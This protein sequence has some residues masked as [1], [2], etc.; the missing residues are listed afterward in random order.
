[1]CGKEED[2]IIY[3]MGSKTAIM[4]WRLQVETPHNPFRYC[5]EYYDD[6][7]DLIYLR[8]RYYDNQ[9]GRFITEDPIKDSLNWYSYCGNNP[10]MFIDPW[11]LKDVPLRQFVEERGGTVVW[12]SSN[13]S[14]TVNFGSA[15]KKTYY[16]GKQ[17]TKSSDSYSSENPYLKMNSSGSYSMY[18]DD[19]DI[20]NDFGIKDSINK[21]SSEY[22]AYVTFT[23][24]EKKGKTY[25]RF[26]INGKEIEYKKVSYNSYNYYTPSFYKTRYIISMGSVTNYD[27]SWTNGEW[28]NSVGE[29]LSVAGEVVSGADWS[30]YASM[31][32]NLLGLKDWSEQKVFPGDVKIGFGQTVYYLSPHGWTLRKI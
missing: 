24:F 16:V 7:T 32:G 22:S 13:R 2:T 8:N 15:G 20:I 30:Y 19:Q 18:I 11:G 25:Q 5:G 6:E 26:V 14:A 17:K 4:L 10:I 1:V 21:Y 28:K 23:L 12:N 3:P 29:I 9:T 27:L 31:A